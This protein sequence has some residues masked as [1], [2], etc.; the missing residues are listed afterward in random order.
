MLTF[1]K[2][3][4]WPPVE[5]ECEDSRLAEETKKLSERGEELAKLQMS[6]ADIKEESERKSAELKVLSTTGVYQ[7]LPDDIS[8]EESVDHVGDSFP[9]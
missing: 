4:L 2:R 8:E 5:E 7:A 3:V 9:P 1:L 6:L